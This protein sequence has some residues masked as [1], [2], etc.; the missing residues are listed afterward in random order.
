MQVACAVA[1]YAIVIGAN[2]TILARAMLAC[3]CAISKSF[4]VISSCLLASLT[5]HRIVVEEVGSLA[6][7]AL[8]RGT[9]LTEALTARQTS[10]SPVIER[11][12][13]ESIQLLAN[14]TTC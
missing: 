2:L 7:D 9:N 5:A 14:R 4:V 1:G 3:D 10:Q 6:P 11:L 8:I 13:V 12:V